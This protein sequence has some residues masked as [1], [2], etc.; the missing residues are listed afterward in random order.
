MVS[1]YL[2]QLSYAII[3]PLLLPAIIPHVWDVE[4]LRSLSDLFFWRS[5]RFGTKLGIDGAE[6]GERCVNIIWHSENS[7]L[8]SESQGEE[9]VC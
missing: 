6:L 3:F 2:I 7:T 4:L 8:K 5:I 1:P 9:G